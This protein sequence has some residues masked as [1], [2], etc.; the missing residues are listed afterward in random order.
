MCIR[1][2]RH[3]IS[4]TAL[5]NTEDSLLDDPRALAMLIDIF[6][7][8]GYHATV[9]LHRIEIPERIDLASGL[10]SNRTKKVYRIQIR[11]TGS[12]IRRG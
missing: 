1:D 11:F 8:R 7:E 3:A 4:G 2:R 6:S 5:V 10:V 9:D 12:E